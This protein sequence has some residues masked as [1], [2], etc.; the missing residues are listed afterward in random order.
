VSASILV[1]YA[2]RY[3]ST[4]E[5]A[6]AV[7]TTLRERGLEVDLQHMRD[8]QS[9]E[10]YS[11]V[12]LGAPIYIGH[13][14]KDAQSFLS[15]HREALMQRKVAIF[16]LGPI[17]TDEKEWEGV[18]TQL[19]QE[20]ANFPWLNPIGLELFGGKYD[21]AKL[22]FPDSLLAKLPVSPLYHMPTSDARDWT[23][24]RA[25]TDRLATELQPALSQ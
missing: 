25:W 9:L 17:Q 20:L 2:S 1:T 14:H 6:A 5:V 11:L 10:G 12:V 23:A 21:P 19:D 3:G 16:T 13:W 24:I 8:V 22:R 15:R 18:H 4:Q 7:T